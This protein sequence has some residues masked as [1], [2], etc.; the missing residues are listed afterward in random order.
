MGW[1]IAALIYTGALVK[2]PRGTLFGSAVAVIL[3]LVGLASWFGYHYVTDMRDQRQ[4]DR[5]A[6][7]A[8]WS[9]GEACAPATPIQVEISNQSERQ[10]DAIT[11]K[12]GSHFIDYSPAPEIS[13]ANTLSTRRIVPADQT[14]SLCF[15]LDEIAQTMATNDPETVVLYSQIQEIEFH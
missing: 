3:G 1:I 9:P 15:A 10:V 11:F 8:N 14:V 13:D 2:Y 4:F 5:V 12:I 6:V 7:M